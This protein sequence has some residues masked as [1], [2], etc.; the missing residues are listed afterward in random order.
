MTDGREHLPYASSFLIGAMDLQLAGKR[1]I[2]TPG[3][4]GIGKAI[5]RELAREGARAVKVLG[6]IGILVNAAAQPG[7][8]E[9]PPRLAEIV[10]SVACPISMSRC[11][12]TS[13]A[14]ARLR[15]TWRRQAAEGSSPSPA[16]PRERPARLSAACV[17]LPLRRRPTRASPNEL[18]SSRR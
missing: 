3:S 18:M 15:R 1:A 12:A 9:R 11:L 4:R 5:A 2:V 6:A 17:T 10:E 8:Q 16:S 7:G 14:S 13:G